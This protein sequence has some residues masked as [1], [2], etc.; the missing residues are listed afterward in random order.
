MPFERTRAFFL[1]GIAA[2]L[3]SFFSANASAQ[4]IAAK[5][6]GSLELFAPSAPGDAL[7]GVN[8]PS[9][10]GHILPRL[11][12]SF[13]YNHKPLS[14]QEGDVRTT[15]INFQIFAHLGA[16]VALF[17]RF[18]VSVDA[19]FAIVQSG[20]ATSSVNVAFPEPK[21]AEVGDVKLGLRARL[22]GQDRE[23][24][25]I[26]VAGYLFM[27]TGEPGSYVSEGEKRGAPELIVGGRVDRYSYSTS[28]GGTFRSSTNARPNTLE[29]RAGAAAHFADDFF[30]I[31]PEFYL[32]TPFTREVLAEDA[33]KRIA[34]ASAVSAEAL[35][36]AKLRPGKFLVL[37][38]GIGPG[39]T[40]GYGTPKFVGTF[41]F[42]FEPGPMQN[43]PVDIA[44][45][46]DTDGDR[47]N[48]QKDA[49]RTIA[50]AP[51][52]DPK[53][54]GC[55]PD[56]DNDGIIDS[57]DACPTVAGLPNEDPKRN[58]CPPDR[59]N[60][61]IFDEKDACP[62]VPGSAN[63]DPQKHGCP[64]DRDEDGIIDEKDACPDEPGK[65]SEDPK[66]NGCPT[67]TVTKKEIVITKQVRFRFGEARLESAV[68]PVS[69]ELLTDVRDAIL[70]HPEIE[71][72]EVQGH[73]DNIGTETFN[74]ELSQARAEA[75][76]LWLIKRGIPEDKIEAKGYGATTPIA[77]NDSKKGRQQNRRVQFVIVAKKNP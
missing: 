42:G 40:Q 74:Q 46:I 32:S 5:P 18:L 63:K 31:G 12:F 14:I 16:S 53:K 10:V 55:P 29:V 23:P 41:S 61:G 47:I 77:E 49:C 38:A 70:N 56:T 66:T 22:F 34:V 36:G 28:V 8:S 21:E 33:T 67:V 11:R 60:D 3:F 73:A 19:P 76:R 54:H 59:D 9:T 69:D 45:D 52:A 4:P 72:I 20:Q 39:L 57:K 68:D 1:P 51:N 26:A 58:G 2:S 48:D 6:S 17:D 65:P 44:T 62:D 15:I 13:D 37:S 64:P 75:V 25:Q 27:P 7:L 30:Q 71:K 35:L 50:G 43:K 24:F